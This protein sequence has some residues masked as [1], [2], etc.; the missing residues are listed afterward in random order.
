MWPNPPETE[1]LVTFIEEIFNGKLH[2]VC[3]ESSPAYSTFPAIRYKKV[4]IKNVSVLVPPFTG[5]K[6]FYLSEALCN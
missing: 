6:C 5:I 2:F 3:S 4:Y 1:D